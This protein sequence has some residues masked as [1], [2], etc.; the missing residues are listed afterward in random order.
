M[1]DKVFLKDDKVNLWLG[2]K[3]DGS[4]HKI[5]YDLGVHLLNYAYLDIE[6]ISEAMDKMIDMSFHE[7]EKDEEI[8]D[9]MICIFEQCAYLIYPIVGFKGQI[10][11]IQKDP[12]CF[13]DEVLD[14]SKVLDGDLK[15][16]TDLPLFEMDDNGELSLSEAKNTV[17]ELMKNNLQELFKNPFSL[18]TLMEL[19]K[20]IYIVDLKK[21]TSALLNDLEFVSKAS[22]R[23]DNKLLSSMQRLYVL[24]TVRKQGGDEAYYTNNQ[25]KTKYIPL[26]EVDDSYKSPT[27]IAGFV[28]GQEIEVVEMYDVDGIDSLVRFEMLKLIDSNTRINRCKHC[29]RL[30]IPK[31]RID[32]EY[33]DRIMKG[34]TKPCSSIGATKIYQNKVSDDLIF[35]AYN[36]AYKR[37]NSRV[38]NKK[39]SQEEFFSWSEE[40]RVKR[41]ECYEGKISLEEFKTWLESNKKFVK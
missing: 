35:E 13:G 24:D 21:K 37:N 14:V 8:N 36:K 7:K 1:S 11:M 3:E 22:N 2:F 25:F 12:N 39:M 33:C 18:R 41:A 17:E 15:D 26:S 16:T 28:Y 10:D 4:C 30:F 32:K 29:D 5:K 20:N 40:A 19:Q 6:S 23:E 9:L 31:G 27:E 34:E 38:R